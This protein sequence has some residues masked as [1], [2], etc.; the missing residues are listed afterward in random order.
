MWEVD[1]QLYDSAANN[2]LATAPSVLVFPTLTTGVEVA[3]DFCAFRADLIKQQVCDKK[4]KSKV[5]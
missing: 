1:Y 4:V 5:K 3:I 2:F